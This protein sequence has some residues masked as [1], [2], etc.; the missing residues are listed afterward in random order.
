MSPGAKQPADLDPQQAASRIRSGAI[1]VDVREPQEWHAGHIPGALHIPLGQLAIRSGE[2]A[3]DVE[4]IAV[5][6]SGVR[7]AEATR[8]LGQAGYAVT[9]LAGGMKAWHRA[10]LPIEPADGRIA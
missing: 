10:G 9:N 5:C 2:L 4:L 8:A 7:S 3:Q 1:V 6:R